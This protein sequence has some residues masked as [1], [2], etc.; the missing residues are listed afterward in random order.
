M[1]KLIRLFTNLYSFT[2]LEPK[3]AVSFLMDPEQGPHLRTPDPRFNPGFAPTFV[4]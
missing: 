4:M 1:V 2:E 3:G